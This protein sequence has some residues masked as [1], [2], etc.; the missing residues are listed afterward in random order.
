MSQQISRRDIVKALGATALIGGFPM[1]GR[2]AELLP[3]KDRRV[4]VIG[5]GFGG[6]IAAKTLRQND[7]S[8]EVVL[9]ERDRLYTACPTSNLV[10]GGSRKIEQ[11]QITLEKLHSAYGVQLVYG[12][13]TAIDTKARKV[14]LASG[15]L[16]YDKLI[17]SPGID[18]RFAEIEGYDAVKTPELMPHAWKAGAQ[19][20]LLRRQLEAMPDDGTVVISVPEGP[21]RAAPGP[22]ERACQIAWYLKRSKAK[23]RIV[24]L[25][26]NPDILAKGALF[27]SVWQKYYPG[28]IDYRPNQKVIRVSPEKMTLHT[29]AGEVK[30]DVVNLI[31]PQYAGL[32]AHQ[33]KL[34]GNDRRWCPVNQTTYESTLVKDI[35]VI[36]DACI[37][38]PVQKSG[39]SANSQGKVCALNLLATMN[40]KKL[41][42]PAVANII[43]S[44]VNDKEA[45]S[46]SAVFRVTDG[47]AI[48]VLGAGGVSLAPSAL[49]GAYALAWI[50]NILAEMSQ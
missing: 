45:V 17:V 13:V 46:Y 50:N 9:V 3:K 4:V 33:A 29:A 32:I 8:I 49:E 11:N 2:S 34:V 10:I 19:T 1:I 47:R 41:W 18:F 42:E 27:K 21:L 25:D 37:A 16:S 30:G 26:A 35:H 6:A 48:A 24:V 20:L 43:Y 40:D 22:Y 12:E 14:V 38:D 5:G 44:F 7:P 15:T 23:S 31:P 39:F 36:G 28:L